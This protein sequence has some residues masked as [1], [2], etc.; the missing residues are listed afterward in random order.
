MGLRDK[1]IYMPG[2]QRISFFSPPQCLKVDLP[3]E[4][5]AACTPCQFS[6]IHA[7]HKP[8]QECRFLNRDIYVGS[9]QDGLPQG[10]GKYLW[11]DG[12]M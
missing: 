7:T 9:W 5:Y 11:S 12:C 10:T 2:L 1:P 4:S 3:E 6:T 8:F